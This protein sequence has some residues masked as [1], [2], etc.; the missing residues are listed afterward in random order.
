LPIVLAQEWNRNDFVDAVEEF[1]LASE[2][3]ELAS[4]GWFE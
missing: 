4:S 3:S 2:I 1:G